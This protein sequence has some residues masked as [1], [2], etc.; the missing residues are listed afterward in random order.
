MKLNE[1]IRDCEYP[2]EHFSWNEIK[3]IFK[4]EIATLL[5]D[6]VR[7]INGNWTSGVEESIKL[8]KEE[9]FKRIQNINFEEFEQLITIKEV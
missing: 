4:K 2:P 8:A 6:G 7:K 3:I 9:L 5:P 1:L